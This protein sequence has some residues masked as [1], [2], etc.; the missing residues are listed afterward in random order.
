MTDPDK[1]IPPDRYKEA[2]GWVDDVLGALIRSPATLALLAVWSLLW[3]ILGAI[4]S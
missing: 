2:E 3:F 1:T 4:V